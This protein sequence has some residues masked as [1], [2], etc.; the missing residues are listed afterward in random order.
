MKTSSPAFTMAQRHFLRGD[1]ERSITDFS[2]AL[3]QGMDADRIDLPFGLAHLKHGD[4][5][6]AVEDFSR[7]LERNPTDEHLFFL[8]GI[9]HLNNGNTGKALD[10]FSMA[11]DL[12]RGRGAAFV[13]RSLVYRVL[14]RDI[15]AEND[16]K[17][18]VAL[19]D[20]EVELFLREYCIAPTLYGLAMS[21]F[22][23]DKAGWGKA[24][25]EER[26]SLTH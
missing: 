11:I 20:V 22:D 7:A 23:V 10:D 6:E 15:E 16:M 14:H 4:F 8:R 5:L 24:L 1:Y 9:A 26:S 3:E 21:L 2:R 25:W 18:A 12:N 19:A 13:A 17:T